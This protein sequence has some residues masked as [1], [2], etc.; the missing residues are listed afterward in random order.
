MNRFELGM[1]L[2]VGS[3]AAG[4]TAIGAVIIGQS[5]GLLYVYGYGNPGWFDFAVTTVGL[6]AFVSMMTG[7]V[8]MYSFNTA[9]SAQGERNGK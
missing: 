5:M 8:L 9:P 2:F 1:W 6:S 3:I 4:M 7:L